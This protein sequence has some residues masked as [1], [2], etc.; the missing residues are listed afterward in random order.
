MSSEST[1]VG[2]NEHTAT[3]EKK[4]YYEPLIHGR[5]TVHRYW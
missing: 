5:T 3:D 2:G 1:S 4:L